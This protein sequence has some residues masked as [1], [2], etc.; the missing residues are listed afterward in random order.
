ME[1]KGEIKMNNRKIEKI[2]M[3]KQT[4]L[5]WKDSDGYARINISGDR[6]KVLQH[7]TKQKHDT[8]K[9]II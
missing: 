1:I 9:I 2:C 5:R 6:K 7:K 4:L 8:F 3:N